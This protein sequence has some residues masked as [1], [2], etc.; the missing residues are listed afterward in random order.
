MKE[1]T[2]FGETG[3]LEIPNVAQVPQYSPLRYPGGK[4]RWYPFVKRWLLSKYEDTIFIEPFAGG[5][6]MGLAAGIEGLVEKVTLVEKNEDVGAFWKTVLEKPD[7][8]AEKVQNFEVSRENVEQV[9]S[10]EEVGDYERGFLLLLHNRMSRGGI[11]AD[12]GGLMKNGEKGKG[13]QSRWYPDTL[14]QRIQTIA[15]HRDRFEFVWGD[16]IEVMKQ[17]LNDEEA[18]FFVDPPYTVAGERLYD[19]SEVDHSGLFNLM[20][21]VEGDFLATYDDAE[22]IRKLADE[23]GFQTEEILMSTNHHEKKFELLIDG[24]F[25]WLN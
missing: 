21:R 24:S 23:H 5:S 25:K 7:W 15:E 8:L 4:S 1:K 2:L 20:A 19:N 18:S 16:G 12:G 3:N 9:F 6:S 22:Q 17:H 13:L 10:K 11:T 14:A